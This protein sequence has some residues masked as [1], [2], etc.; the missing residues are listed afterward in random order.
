MTAPDRGATYQIALAST[1]SSTHNI[2]YLR[3]E[4]ARDPTL[5]FTPQTRE[6]GFRRVRR[7]R[8]QRPQRWGAKERPSLAWCGSDVDLRQS[9]AGP[10]WRSAWERGR[11][12][13]LGCATC[14]G[15]RSGTATGALLRAGFSIFI[16]SPLLICAPSAFVW[17]VGSGPGRGHDSTPLLAEVLTAG[18]MQV[19]DVFGTGRFSSA[20]GHRLSASP[21]AR[22]PWYLRWRSARGGLPPFSFAS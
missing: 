19:P 8:T 13:P 16:R 10:Q 5:P 6:V 18:L 9:S 1:G 3:S 15:E 2:W 14:W 4:S 22:S 7:P 21:C 12:L 11:G 17:A 20:N